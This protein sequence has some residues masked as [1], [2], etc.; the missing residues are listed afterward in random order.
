VVLAQ[1]GDTGAACGLRPRPIRGVP[2]DTTADR[3]PSLPPTTATTP[4]ASG[5]A[6]A[7]VRART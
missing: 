6:A 3:R 7:R 4:P 2:A 1:T 5:F